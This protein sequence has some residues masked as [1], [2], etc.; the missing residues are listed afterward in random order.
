MVFSSSGNSI[1]RILN[2]T[3]TDGD[4]TT[5]NS[6]P[7]TILGLCTKVAEISSVVI[8]P[9]NEGT[10]TYIN[11]NALIGHGI[12]PSGQTPAPYAIDAFILGSVNTEFKNNLLHNLR[13]PCPYVRTFEVG[14]VCSPTLPIVN[15]TLGPEFDGHLV[16]GALAINAGVNTGVG[17]DYAYG[18]RPQGTAYDIGAYEF[19]ATPGV[20]TTPTTPTT[21]TDTTAPTISSI[22]ANPIST[23]TATIL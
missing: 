12:A 19:G 1:I 23:S 18:T 5:N 4:T 22:S 2:N 13:I 6:R 10:K 9:C 20:P 17:V 14:T 8:L 3:I 15:S 11:N 16:A 7:P 21:P